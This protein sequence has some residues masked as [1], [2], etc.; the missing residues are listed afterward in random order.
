SAAPRAAGTAP[1]SATSPRA[2]RSRA[3]APAAWRGRTT[4]RRSR[5][6]PARRKR[7]ELTISWLL[8]LGSSPC[9]RKARAGCH[10]VVT[11]SAASLYCSRHRRPGGPGSCR[12]VRARAW[13]VGWRV[14][15]CPDTSSSVT[16]SPQPTPAVAPHQASMA[17]PLLL[18]R[19]LDVILVVL[20][21]P[22]IV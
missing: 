19:W 6:R 18:F 8:T 17:D 11:K 1:A 3:R 4:P 20:A 16:H 21:A 22:F 7:S 9:A 13:L 5:T 14:L 15:S 2:G 12:A 10:K